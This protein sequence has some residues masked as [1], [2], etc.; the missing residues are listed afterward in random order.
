M[1]TLIEALLKQALDALPEDLVPRAARE[2]S[3]EVENTRDALHGDFASNLA[4]RLGK[5]ARQNPR[6]VAEALAGALPRSPALA[7]VEIAGAGFINFFLRDDAYHQEIGKVLS[8]G[9]GYGRSNAGAGRRMQVEFVSANPTGPLHVAH[10]RHAYQAAI[11]ANEP[12]PQE[13][14]DQFFQS[15]QLY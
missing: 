15:F 1:K 13:Q 14:V 11:I 8:E 4:M 6:K 3:I 7:K 12:L 9:P 10:G 5:A 2:V